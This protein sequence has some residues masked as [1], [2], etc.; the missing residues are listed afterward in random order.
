MFW[1]SIIY[2][3]TRTCCKADNKVIPFAL[4]ICH[5]GGIETIVTRT[6]DTV[7]CNKKVKIMNFRYLLAD[8]GSLKRVNDHVN[9]PLS[10]GYILSNVF[11]SSSLLTMVEM[12]QS[13]DKES[14]INAR[15][16]L[17]VPSNINT[18]FPFCNLLLIV[19]KRQRKEWHYGFIQI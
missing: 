7:F 10:W 12:V 19:W 14:D 1:E 5:K 6:D 16:T 11:F 17:L 9:K 4:S 15:P 3:T 8:G 2:L 18:L 13:K